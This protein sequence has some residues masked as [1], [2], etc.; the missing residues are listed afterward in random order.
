MDFNLVFDVGDVGGRSSGHV[1]QN[2]DLVAVGKES[3][4]EVR[5]DKTGSTRDE[6]AHGGKSNG[7]GVHLSR[8]ALC[9]G[10]DNSQAEKARFGYEIGGELS[11]AFGCGHRLGSVVVGYWLGA[12]F[13]AAD[14]DDAK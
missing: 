14:N 1:V 6:N 12:D 7:A 11:Q 10:S 3:I 5:T 2:R 13:G 4:T 8:L 9:R